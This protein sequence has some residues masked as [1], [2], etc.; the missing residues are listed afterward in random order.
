MGTTTDVVTVLHPAAE[1]VAEPQ[2][3]APRLPSLQGTTVG[4]I[5]NHK[6]NADVYLEALGHLLQE[7][8]GVSQVVTYRKISQ[9]LPTPDEVLD[10]LASTCDAIIHAVAD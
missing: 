5:D 8:Y 4:L 6:R 10:Q 2:R 1:D 3:L 9:S 7:R